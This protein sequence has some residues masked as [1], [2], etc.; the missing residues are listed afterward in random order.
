MTTLNCK[1][2]RNALFS[3]ADTEW[4]VSIKN[5]RSLALL[6]F[7]KIVLAMLRCVARRYQG[8][9]LTLLE[10]CRGCCWSRYDAKPE[11]GKENSASLMQ[12]KIEK[13]ECFTLG[14][15]SSNR[16]LLWRPWFLPHT[17]SHSI[18]IYKYIYLCVSL[19][20]TMYTEYEFIC[21]CIIP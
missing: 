20:K 11:I 10:S 15:F 21:R 3:L 7:F 16:K 18:L 4:H 5:G 14:K 6:G 9:G 13:P 19:S 17:P 1:C 8:G 12:M 2:A